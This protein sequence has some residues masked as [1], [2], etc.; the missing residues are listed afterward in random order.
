MEPDIVKLANGGFVDLGATMFL[1]SGLVHL[2]SHLFF[3]T[4]LHNGPEFHRRAFQ[5]LVFAEIS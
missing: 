2:V 3:N 4:A 5:P 1:L